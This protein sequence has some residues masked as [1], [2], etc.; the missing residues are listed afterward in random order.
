MLAASIRNAV[1]SEMSREMCGPIRELCFKYIKRWLSC[2]VI[3]LDPTYF[4]LSVSQDSTIE[5]FLLLVLSL[6]LWLNREEVVNRCRASK[7]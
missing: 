7:S 4:H 2:S 3:L 5:L 1:P 6:H